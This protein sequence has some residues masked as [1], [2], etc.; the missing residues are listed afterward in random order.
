LVQIR[1]RQALRGVRLHFV[2]GSVSKAAGVASAPRLAQ[3]VLDAGAGQPAIIARQAWAHGAPPSARPAYGTVKLAFVHHTENPNGYSSAEVPAMLLAIYQFHRFVRRWDDIGY[4]FVIDRFGRIWEARQG[5]IARAVIGAQ[6][7]GY[8]AVSTGVAVLGSFMDVV[9]SQAALRSLEHLLAWKLS[10]HGV[11]TDGQVTVVVNPADAFYTPFKPGAHVSLPR[12]AGHRDG[13]STN[14]PGNAFY[15]RL[16]S[17]RPRISAL[18]GTPLR[19]DLVRPHGGLV[20]PATAALTGRLTHLHGP[21]AAG[22]QVEVQRV[23]PHSG[24]TL[25]VTTTGVDG[26]WSVALGLVHSTLVQAVSSQAPAAVSDVV[27][28]AVAPKIDASVASTAPLIITGTVNPAKHRVVVDVYGGGG[29]LVKR[30]RV[31]VAGGRFRARFTL[32]GAGP[33]SVVV[34]TEA[35]RKNAAGA[36]ARLPVG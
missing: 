11:P 18:A 6:A 19:L 10:L 23:T 28:V 25:A 36:S 24:Q 5:G 33:Y 32:G 8:N 4:N 16:P 13:D 27:E 17:L 12:I 34:R 3:P 14:C 35:D 22:A 29:R 26:S 31:R 21:P 2:A 7:G 9:P 30:K 1:S 20:A 15:R